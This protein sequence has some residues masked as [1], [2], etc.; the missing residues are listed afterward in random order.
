[1]NARIA[2]LSRAVCFSL[3]LL[4]LGG[5]SADAQQSTNAD[6]EDEQRSTE[7]P[8]KTDHRDVENVVEGQKP[9]TT[10]T[11]KAGPLRVH[12]SNPRYF[13]DDSGK[14]LYM[15]G[16]QVWYVLHEGNHPVN[17]KR[18]TDFLDWMKS[19]GHNY[20]R[21]W[22]NWWYLK[23][24]SKKPQKPWPYLR[25]GPG[26]AND[27]LPK[28]DLSKPNPEYFRLLRFYMQE[29]ENRDMYCSI[30]LFGSYN[31]FRS[32][33]KNNI[34]WH[35]DNNINPETKL[36][37]RNTD[38][39]STNAGLLALQEAQV[40]RVIDSLNEFDNFIWEVINEAELPASRNW[41]VHMMDVIR[42]YEKTK[43]Q[44]HLILMGGG[45]NEAR[46][47]LVDSPADVI[48]PDTYPR[49]CKS[50][51]P[52]GYCGKIIINDT[53]H[54]WGFSQR[55]NRI[56]MEKWVWQTM[57]R[58]NHPLFMDHYDSPKSIDHAWDKLRLNLGYTIK[59]ANKIKDLAAMEPS[60][61]ISSTSYCLCN[62]GNEYLV[63][64]PGTE[65]FTVDMTSGTYHRE[66]FDPDD[67]S[68]SIDTMTVSSDGKKTF[69]IPLPF[70]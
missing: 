36:L 29:L 12:S 6:A 46:K 15:A 3:A 55:S 47:I 67:A 28:F 58:G 56:A 62:V 21:T 32:N 31:Q 25:T 43:P 49:G 69:S 59:Y 8:S 10:N 20:T 51:G 1:M 24:K 18:I 63:Y 53:D 19:Q 4:I 41:R 45:H 23:H 57:C 34:A 39:F 9:N 68:V 14:P 7:R 5:S 33:F 22:S 54:L 52:V 2:N 44:Q 13:T 42:T 66:W 35:P 11:R 27:G 64:Q 37:S 70:R 50:G 60:A 38:F 16:S 26:N 40:K 17:E 30:L 61:S 65:P 48:S